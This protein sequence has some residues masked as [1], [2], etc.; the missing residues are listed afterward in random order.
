ME[1]RSSAVRFASCSRGSIFAGR[2]RERR[3]S[4]GVAEVFPYL[5]RLHRA[6]GISGGPFDVLRLRLE[7]EDA[8]RRRLSSELPEEDSAVRRLVQDLVD[9][10]LDRET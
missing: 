2:E 3:I 9:A 1:S 8:V 5:E 6:G 4:E 7:L 10:Q